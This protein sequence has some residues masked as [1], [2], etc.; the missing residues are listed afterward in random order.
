M[1]RLGICYPPS[2]GRPSQASHQKLASNA[3]STNPSIW[4]PSRRTM[5]NWSHQLTVKLEVRR[6]QVHNDGHFPSFTT[7]TLALNGSR[8]G[9]ALAL[10][11]SSKRLLTVKSRLEEFH[12]QKSLTLIL[13]TAQAFEN[14][15]ISIVETL[16]RHQPITSGTSH[17]SLDGAS[18]FLSGW[19]GESFFQPDEKRLWDIYLTILNLLFQSFQTADK[20]NRCRGVSRCVI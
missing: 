8:N 2:T 3:S 16:S 18:R 17:D 7:H 20:V 14:N 13:V 15:E 4:T 1:H 9:A 10:W 6:F 12:S 5:L 11:N 19:T